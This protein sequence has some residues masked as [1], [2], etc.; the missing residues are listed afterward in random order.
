MTPAEMES[1]IAELEAEVRALRLDAKAQAH[2]EKLQRLA[3]PLEQRL[4]KAA[5]SKKPRKDLRLTAAEVT[6]LG[7][8]YKQ[9]AVI[10]GIVVG[11]GQGKIKAATAKPARASVKSEA[12]GPVSS[13]S[14]DLATLQNI[15]KLKSG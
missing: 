1:R 3:A 6:A 4:E 13:G 7:N 12:S 8:V 9:M 11:A 2:L 15:V 10:Q 14:A 5:A